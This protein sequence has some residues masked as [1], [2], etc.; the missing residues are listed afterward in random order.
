MSLTYDNVMK[1]LGIKLRPTEI[2]ITVEAYALKAGGVTPSDIKYDR[3]N[4]LVT[5]ILGGLT[6]YVAKKYA[7]NTAMTDFT[8]LMRDA[9]TGAPKTGLTVAVSISKDGAA[10][11]AATNTPA[12]EVVNATGGLGTYKITIAQ[13]ETNYSIIVLTITATGALPLTI[14]IETA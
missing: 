6:S 12:T 10:P 13:A 5:C 11:V 1:I 2:D 3:T 9:T 8:F 14:C 7:K 4:G